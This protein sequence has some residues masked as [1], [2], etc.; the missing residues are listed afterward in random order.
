MKKEEKMTKKLTNERKVHEGDIIAQPGMVYDFEKISGYL[1]A[2]GADTR[3]A[4]PKLKQQEAGE[5]AMAKCRSA[6][7]AALALHGLIL[8]DGI[9]SR[10]ISKKAGVYRV[11]VVGQSK[12]SYVIE[13]DGQTAHGATLQLARADLLF[14]LGRRDTSAFREWKRETERPLEEMIAAYRAITGACGAGVQHFLAGKKYGPKVSVDFMLKETRGQYGHD[15]LA[16]F[17]ANAGAN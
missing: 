13:R 1:R 8:Q 12:V 3:T 15:K 5:P 4:F 6:L 9:L 11:V 14:K 2:S 17:F 16:A 7:V 10:I